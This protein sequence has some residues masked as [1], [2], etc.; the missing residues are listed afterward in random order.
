MKSILIVDDSA[1]VR[2]NLTKLIETLTG[3]QIIAAV[4][5]SPGVIKH[6]EKQNPDIV[7]LDIDLEIGNGIEILSTIKNLS[8]ATK[9]IMFTN[10][11]N[12]AFRRS[13]LKLG[14]DYFLDKTQD[15]EKLMTILSEL[16]EIELT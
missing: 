10:Y 16:S 1:E 5:D 13:T 2:K 8:P 6:F 7:I 14:A 4:G 3:V 9:V 11:A 15:V 12:D